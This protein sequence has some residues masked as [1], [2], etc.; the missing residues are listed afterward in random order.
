M[1]LINILV[2][3]SIVLLYILMVGRSVTLAFQGVNPL[4]LGS[5]KKGFNKFL[6]RFFAVTLL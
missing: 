1:R 3:T 4:V 2:I 6:E 5:G